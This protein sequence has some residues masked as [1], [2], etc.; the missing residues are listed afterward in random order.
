M[1]TDARHKSRWRRSEADIT[2]IL[3]T[4]HERLQARMVTAEDLD[5]RVAWGFVVG[6][7]IAALALIASGILLAR[8]YRRA[9]ASKTDAASHSGKR[10]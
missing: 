3:D 9:A 1:N 8:A 6:S 4:A 5:Q 7:A 2:G 10:A